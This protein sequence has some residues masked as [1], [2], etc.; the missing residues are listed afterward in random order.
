[1]I[2]R[3]RSQVKYIWFCVELEHYSSL[4]AFTRDSQFISPRDLSLVAKTIQTLLTKLSEWEPSGELLLD[5]SIHSPSDSDYLL[6][7][8]TF[9]PDLASN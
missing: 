5:I 3:N 9:G 6:K 7:Y 1:M 8:L 4:E 2:R